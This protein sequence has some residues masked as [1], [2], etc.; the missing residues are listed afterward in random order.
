MERSKKECILAEA[1]K[2]FARFGFKKASVD[3]I[4]KGAGV[5]KGTV[6]LAAES[7]EDLFYQVLHREIRAWTA[8]CASIIDHRTPADRLL[9]E[10][11][12]T[13]MEYLHKRPLVLELL[14]GQTAQILPDWADRLET[15]R[16]LGKANISEVLRLGISQKVFREDLEV[17]TVAS[18]LQDFNLAGHLFAHRRGEQHDVAFERARIGLDLVLNGLYTRTRPAPALAIHALGPA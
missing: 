6:Y 9:A 8:E 3:D 2:A 10:L 12:Q 4:A 5:G 14:F 7:K 13:A 15:L 16:A 11:L 18:L 1:A 17:D